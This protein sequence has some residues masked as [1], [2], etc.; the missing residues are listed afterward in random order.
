MKNLPLALA[1]AL[2]LS[3]VACVDAEVVDPSLDD[4]APLPDDA[5]VYDTVATLSPDG[6]VVMSAPRAITVAEQ[7]AQNLERMRGTEPTIAAAGYTVVGRPPGQDFDCGLSSLWVYS[8][9]DYTGDRICFQGN[10]WF[11]LGEYSRFAMINGHPYFG[12]WKIPSGSF[13]AGYEPGSFWALDPATGT[14]SSRT[15][16]PYNLGTF[17]FPNPLTYIYLY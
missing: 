8:R 6:S 5:V 14:Y 3:S 7:R 4:G 2:A 17:Q 9:T 15:F 11:N 12:N 10:S 13:S 1:C 16:A